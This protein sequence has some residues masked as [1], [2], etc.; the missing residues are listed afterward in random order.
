[1]FDR[2]KFVSEKFERRTK[3]VTLKDLKPWFGESEPAWLVRGLTGEELSRVNE[4]ANKNAISSKLLEL[5]M[6]KTDKET[7]DAVKAQLGLGDD[8]PADLARRLEMLSIGS[9]EPE[10]DIELAVRLA[11]SFPIEFATLTNEITTL[12]G[13]GSVAVAKPSPSGESQE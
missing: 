7:L 6:A 5:V 4:A 13:L 10:V 1:M 2:K 9:V 12:T 8:T 11:E 3:K